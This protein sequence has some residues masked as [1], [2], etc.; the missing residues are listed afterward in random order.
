MSEETPNTPP[1]V[2]EHGFPDNTPTADMAPEHQAAYWKHHARKHEQRAAQAPDAAELDSLRAA[3]KELADRKAAEL[4][5]AERLQEE[6]SAADDART[7]AERERDEAR[8]ELLRM[9][10]AADKGLT[11]AQA[12]RLQGSTKEELE[13]DADE[14][15]KLFAPAASSTDTTRRP[16]TRTGSDVGPAKSVTTGEERYKAR[17]GN[18]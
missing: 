7:V 16:S 8:A 1:A 10:V 11:P 18:T 9:R 12:G 6:K 15:K 17:F 5:D 2:N 14:L 4:S 3:A 13:A